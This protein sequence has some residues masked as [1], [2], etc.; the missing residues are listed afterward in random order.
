MST[1]P[2]IIIHGGAGTLIEDRY[3]EKEKEEYYSTLEDSLSKGYS[4]LSE[5]GSSLEA[6][7][8]S[9]AV[10][11]DSPLF[12]AGKGSVFSSKGTIEMDASL[13]SGRDL[14]AG[15]VSCLKSVKNPIYVAK[16]VLENC[17]HVLLS[18]EGALSF[19]KE[20]KLPLMPDEYFF[21]EK[22]WEQLVEARKQ[23][24][25]ILDH[26]DGIGTVGAVALDKNGDISAGTSTG[27]LTNRVWGRCSDSGQIGAGNYANNKTCAVSCTGTGDDFIRRVFAYDLSAMIEYKEMTL[28]ESSK[29]ALEK[30]RNIGGNG[31]VIVLN[32]KGEFS[33]DFIS[34]GMFRGYKNSQKSC[35]VGIFSNLIERE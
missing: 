1:I 32:S 11:E 18:G 13:M 17:E 34:A 35:H 6:V 29:Q 4:C 20:K 2:T 33:L 15:A 14:S 21:S 7:C 22:R 9:I 23:G 5:G 24:K 26:S 27:G 16:E 30:L 8:V 25:V 3:S 10:L 28:E 19:S 12:N 31:G